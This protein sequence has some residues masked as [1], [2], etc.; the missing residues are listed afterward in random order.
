MMPLVEVLLTPAEFANL[1][2]RDLHDTVCVVFDVLRA[3]SSILT[4]LAHGADSILPAADI[5]EALALKERFPD[6]LLAGERNGL[7]IR[8]HL[9][10]GVEFDLG[11]SPAEFSPDQ[12]RGRR[13]IMTTTN[14]TRALRACATARQV[15]VGALLNLEALTCLLLR[16]RPAQLLL[17]CSGTLDHAAFED[18]LAAGALCDTLGQLY[19]PPA[20]SDS[21]HL[22]LHAYH[23]FAANLS[24]GIALGRNGRRL[25][26]QPDLRDDVAFCATCNRFPFVP[27]LTL[28]GAVRRFH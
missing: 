5:A 7:R 4:A 12:V 9:T 15:L 13:I 19:P 2:Q 26:A 16:L 10:G 8:A 27:Y 14:G 17:V 24:A 3:T 21:A 1:R 25:L 28:D 23:P 18:T 6:A 20:L 22:A 11:N